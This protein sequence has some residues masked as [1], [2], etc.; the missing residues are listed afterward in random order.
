[1]E[2]DL[3]DL[4]YIDYISAYILQKKILEEIK[5]KLRKNTLIFCEHP[6]TITLGRKSNLQNILISKSELEK[7]GIK[8]YSVDRG[9]DVTYHGPGQLLIYPILDLSFWEKD[10]RKFLR[11]LE[12]LILFTLRDFGIKSQILEDLRGVWVGE[13]KICSIG[14]GIKNWISFHGLSLNVNTDLKYFDLIKPCGLD[15]RMTSIEEILRERQDINKVKE[16]ILE[17]FE[18][19]FET[20]NKNIFNASSREFTDKIF[21]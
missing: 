6:H 20:F 14:V 8:V 17:N 9:G 18:I 21:V 1:M 13:K 15:I 12:A 5:L 16:K 3:I 11:R 10:I 4:G 7:M 2:I 19:V